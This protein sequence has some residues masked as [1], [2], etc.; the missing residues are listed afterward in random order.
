MDNLGKAKIELNKLVPTNVFD[1]QDRD[2]HLLMFQPTR[3]QKNALK[4]FKDEMSAKELLDTLEKEDR[5]MLW[6]S[7]GCGKSYMSKKVYDHYRDNKKNCIIA[8]PSNAL[9][10]RLTREGYCATTHFMLCGKRFGEEGNSSI[11]TKFSNEEYDLLIL[12]ECFMHSAGSWAMLLDY[13]KQHPKMKVL[14]NGDPLQLEP[15][16][17]DRNSTVDSV[18]YYSTIIGE[19]LPTQYLLEIPK[20]YKSDEHKKRALELR[21]MLF[22][23]K[24]PREAI[25]RRFAKPIKLADAPKDAVYISYT[26]ETR[27]SINLRVHRATNPGKEDYYPGLVLRCKEANGE[28][29]DR[30]QSNWDYKIAELNEREVI[31]EDVMDGSVFK[32]PQ[33]FLPR[34]MCHLHAFTAHSLQGDTTDKPVIICEYDHYCVNDRWLYVALTRSTDLDNVYYATDNIQVKYRDIEKVIAG[35]KEQ[36]KKKGRTYDEKDYIDVSWWRKTKDFC[37]HCKQP[38]S[39]AAPAGDSSLATADRI[40]NSKAHTKDNCVKSCVLCNVSRH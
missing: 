27:S 26:Q 32:R 11:K 15:V 16:E 40:D 39:L 38:I 35:Y 13:M 5:V 19:V 7:A 25:V 22:E 3:V 1:V 21:T 31:L 30:M 10:K 34:K 20:R 36:D 4:A 14:G 23:E 18:E 2:D 29:A 28:G 33:S 6:G 17:H 12:E 24:V 9:A 8:C 37:Y